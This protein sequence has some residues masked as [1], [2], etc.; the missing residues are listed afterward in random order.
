MLFMV[1]EHYV[2]DSKQFMSR[3]AEANSWKDECN[4][5]STLS[6]TIIYVEQKRAATVLILFFEK[7][8]KASF[9]IH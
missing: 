8:P 6:D 1:D 3:S 2:S 9:S 5:D 7:V 4:G